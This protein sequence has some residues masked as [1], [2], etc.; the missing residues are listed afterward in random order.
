[1]FYHF[2]IL[3]L[4]QTFVDLLVDHLALCDLIECVQ[5]V[6]D[7]SA[8][9]VNLIAQRRDPRLL[10]FHFLRPCLELRRLLL[11]PLLL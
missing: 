4:H 5:P 6:H 10:L 3:Y 8:E 9:V 11:V 7:S 2:C 1:M